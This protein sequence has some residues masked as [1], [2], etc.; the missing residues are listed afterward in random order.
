MV[1]APLMTPM[2]MAPMPMPAPSTP[3]A[4]AP[5]IPDELRSAPGQAGD[6]A[7]ESGPLTYQVYTAESLPSPRT[8][9]SSMMVSRTSFP[10]IATKPSIALRVGLGLAAVITVIGT[11]LLIVVGASEDPKTATAAAKAAEAASASLASAAPAMIA[12]APSAPVAEPPF[13]AA[14]A[15]SDPPPPV[16]KAAG[17]GTKTKAAG[18][19]APALRGVAIPPNPFGAGA[20]TPAKPPAKKK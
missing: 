1:N 3:K 7:S 17:K 10:E 16:T 15:P 9:R 11:I 19:S 18:S 5:A 20:A 4:F 6:D 13:V 14:P 12:S 8:S 2:M